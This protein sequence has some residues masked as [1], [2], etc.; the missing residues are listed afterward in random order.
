MWMILRSTDAK[1]FGIADHPVVEAGADGEQ[2]VAV[3]HRHVRLV[4]AVHA[5]HAEE[6][7]VARRVAAE[8]HQ[9][10]RAREAE[11]VDERAQLGRRVA[12]DHP[13]AGVDV[14]P[15]GGEQQLHRLADLPA[16]ALLHRV[17]RAHLDAR[18]IVVRRARHRDILRD[19]D[20][21]RPG[22]AG[23]GD[24]EGLLDRHREV[25]DVLDQEI[26]LDHRA[27][28][29]DRVALLERVEADRRRRHLAGDD[30]HRDRV[31]VGRRDAGDGV[32]DAGPGGD[33]RDADLAGRP[34]VA[35]GGVHRRL[36]VADQH[37]LDR[38][39]LVERVVDVED[40]AARVA[41][42]VADVLCLQAANQDLG[43]VRLGG[44]GRRGAG[45]GAGARFSEGADD[46]M[47]FTSANFSDEKPSVHLSTPS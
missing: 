15:L 36:L 3:L 33:E 7:R 11:Q 12:E 18:R 25:A 43:A 28:D 6:L 5:Q 47:N 2:H 38:V 4:G 45:A 40:R 41:P 17:V 21:D 23:A 30:D 31:H 37:V 8:A 1:C 39:L 24:V 9:R 13:A 26:V 19:V 29:A 34:R 14:R 22:P 27:R 46:S 20:H 44:S 16:V 42:E 10:V 35:V 32:G